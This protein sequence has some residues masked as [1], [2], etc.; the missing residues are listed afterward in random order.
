ME[1]K[2]PI[3]ID[4]MTEWC[5]P[6]KWM[7]REVFS[8][9]DVAEF[10]NEN[11]I[12]LKLDAQKN[13]IIASQYRVRSY[14]TMIY[15]TP[16]AKVILTVN[17]SRQKDDFKKI[18]KQILDLYANLNSDFSE[19]ET[20]DKI[21]IDLSEKFTEKDIRHIIEYCVRYIPKYRWHIIRKYPHLIIPEEDIRDIIKAGPSL[22]KEN[23]II[24]NAMALEYF[25]TFAFH[26]PGFIQPTVSAMRYMEFK[27]S[28][29]L[30]SLL[31]CY[32]AFE[33]SQEA[34]DPDT[35]KHQ[36]KY[37][38]KLVRDYPFCQVIDLMIKAIYTV[39]KTEDNEK[40][41]KSVIEEMDK[42]PTDNWTFL[43]HDLYALALYKS[44]QTSEAIRHIQTAN[45]KAVKIGVK[46]ISTIS[47]LN[48]Y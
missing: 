48:Q 21:I 15:L 3:L 46:Y 1:E 13:G 20:L 36:K 6:C 34:G 33:L 40:F 39:G 32:Y 41:Y 43:S 24:R 7:E 30:K 2:K 38:K 22:I 42:N 11:F 18:G 23:K 31:G 28:H 5:G 14:P 10:Y 4:F 12:N 37:S 44:N 27:D 26:D 29:E 35:E 8:D 19:F 9:P 16:D 17:G 25:R 45:D 47:V